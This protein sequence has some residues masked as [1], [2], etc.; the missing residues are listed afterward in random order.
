MEIDN[1]I[2]LGCGECRPYCPVGAIRATHG[3]D[4]GHVPPEHVPRRDFPEGHGSKPKRGRRPVSR[5]G[6][7]DQPHRSGGLR[8]M[9][10]VPPGRSLPVG[11]ASPGHARLASPSPEPVQRSLDR[12]SADPSPGPGHGRDENQR[13]DRPDPA[14]DLRRLPRAGPAGRRDD[15]PG[16]RAGNPESALA[17]PSRFEPRNPLTRLLSDPA[18]GT[19]D[20]SILGERVMSVFVEIHVPGEALEA[21][22]ADVRLLAPKLRTVLSV[23]L[24]M[25]NGR[26]DRARAAAVCRKLGI[27]P[28]PNGKTN[29]GLGRPAFTAIP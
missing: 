1:E 26:S 6:M 12:S 28:R 21:L 11:G 2:C 14:G 29:V 17:T 15:L 3:E 10:R 23:G 7:P 22:L 25:K 24:S 8:R 18:K 19:L 5:N 9:R 4:R 13:R 20:P 27:A 16:G